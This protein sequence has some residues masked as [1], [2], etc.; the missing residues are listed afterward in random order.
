MVWLCEIGLKTVSLVPKASD[1]TNS[2]L[3]CFIS[4]FDQ[5]ALIF[6]IHYQFIN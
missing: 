3:F 4:D 1:K 5:F 2:Q 6:V